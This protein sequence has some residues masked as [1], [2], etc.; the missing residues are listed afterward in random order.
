MYHSFQA[1]TASR[2]VA[3]V[4]AVCLVPIGIVAQLATGSIQGLVSDKTG[5]IV[6]NATITVTNSSTGVSRTTVSN[7]DGLY[8]VPNLQPA[9]YTVTVEAKDFSKQAVPNV[10]VVVGGQKT[11]NFALEPGEATENVTVSEATVNIDTVSSTVAPVVS[12]RTIVDLPLNGRDWGQLAVLQPG[13]DPVRTQPQVAVSNQRANRGV[14]N[15]LTIGGARPQSNNYRVD[16]TSINDYSNGGPG[17]VLGSNLGVDAIREFSVVTSN[18]T[19]DYGKTSGGVVNAVTRS[20]TNNWHG[21]AYEFLRNSAFDARNEFDAP[22]QIAEFR[23]NQFGGSVGGPIVKDKTFFFANYEGLRQFQGANV[24]ST[25]PS[26]AARQGNLVAGHVNV[27]PAVVPYLQFYPLPNSTVTGDTGT[28]LFNDPLTTDENYFTVKG[29][30]VFSQKDTLSGT[31]FYDGGSIIAPDPFNVKVTGN[32]D[33]RQMA[34]LS[35]THIFSSSLL[36]TV[37]FGYSRVVSIA[38]TT[39]SLVNP[40]AGNP[41]LGFVPGLPVG[42]INIGGI[43]NFQGGKG[44]VGEFDFH[45]NSYQVYDDVSWTKGKHTLQ[46]G[47]AFERLQNNQL[48]TANPNG[49]YTFSSLANFL[50]NRPSTF[51]APISSAISPKDLRQSVYGLYITDNYKILPN[52]TLNLGLRYEP[53]SVPYVNGNQISN[54]RTLTAPQPVLGAPYFLNPTHLNFAPRVGFSW[55]PFKTGQT[56]IRAAYGIYDVLPL[57]YLF[58]GLS[59][60]GAP[61]FQQGSVANLAPGTFPTGAFPLLKANNLRYSLN[62]FNPGRSYVQ[63]WNLNIQ[64]QLPGQ[65]VF[66]MGYF[67]TAGVRLPYRIDDANTVQP[68]LVV[69]NNY[70]FPV[71]RGSGTR[72]NPTVGQISALY[73]TGHSSYNA[74]QVMLTKHLVK[75]ISGNVSYTWGKSLDDG[76]SSTFGDTFANSISS[77]PLWAP[78][79][80]RGLSDFNIAQD[81]VANAVYNLPTFHGSAAWP[82]NGWQIGGIVQVSTGLPFSALISGDALGL[83]SADPFDFPNRL[84]GS[85]CQGSPVNPQNRFHYIKTACFAFPTPGT[86]LGSSARNSITGPGLRNVD[87]TFMKNNMVKERLNIQFRTDLFNIFNFVNYATPLKASTQLFTQ[88]GAPI[89]SAGTLTQTSTSSRQIQFAVK[90]IF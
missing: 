54:L 85:N 76:S 72:I 49:Q 24:A 59:I 51:N 2:L 73:F 12:Q 38:P 83:N 66:Q 4:A 45:Y 52:L 67:G 21:T 50:T 39:I 26:A 63:Q 5:A 16:G 88:A 84:T 31:Y 79:R 61:F 41:A 29:D 8:D 60:F 55:D 44:A 58:E 22:G 46:M 15:Q 1:K 77:L 40:Q 14:G 75:S 3:L 37:R 18:P 89:A 70:F 11:V 27:D 62:Q 68:T 34:G 36:N 86:M 17:G 78:P 64:Q 23:R 82:I 87:L 35:E 13:V 69:N 28:F 80:R 48:G 71:P 9:D 7:G 33:R 30:Q 32:Y 6:P 57:N 65:T 10:G 56:V 43:S 25:V 42:L 53:A 19:A 90:L 47:F 81:F 20:G 74:L